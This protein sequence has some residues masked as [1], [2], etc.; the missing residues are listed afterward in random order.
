MYSKTI[1]SFNLNVHRIALNELITQM[2]RAF[3]KGVSFEQIIYDGEFKLKLIMLDYETEPQLTVNGNDL[4]LVT[5]LHDTM[6]ILKI[7]DAAETLYVKQYSDIE[8]GTVL[9]INIEK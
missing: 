6:D 9:R 7:S 8:T 5:T 2:Q 3:E 4:T 1:N